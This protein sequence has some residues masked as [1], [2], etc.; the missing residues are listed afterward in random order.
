VVRPKSQAIHHRQKITRNNIVLNITQ[1]PSSGLQL[2]PMENKSGRGT[3]LAN[4][5]TI[6][7]RKSSIIGGNEDLQS[8]GINS[9]SRP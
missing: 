4:N 9:G 5:N 2:K 8:A 6:P 7:T 3:A 1:G